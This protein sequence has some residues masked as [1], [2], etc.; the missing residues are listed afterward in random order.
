MRNNLPAKSSTISISWS[1]HWTENMSTNPSSSR[2]RSK[3]AV[4]RRSLPD[5]T[6][7]QWNR[8]MM[9][10]LTNN[11]HHWPKLLTST[12][13][14]IR[15]HSPL[16]LHLGAKAISNVQ[17]RTLLISKMLLRRRRSAVEQR[18]IWDTMLTCSEERHSSHKRMSRR[19]I[20]A[21]IGVR[22]SWL[23]RKFNNNE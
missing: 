10:E 17:N 16:Y 15:I 1:T 11:V 20:T 18:R 9:W 13:S 4:S 14:G 7:F 23:H 2:L 19:P 21:A 5:S 12:D 8:Q 22:S 3:S 6:W